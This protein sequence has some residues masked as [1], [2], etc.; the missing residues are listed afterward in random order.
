VKRST[1]Q[2]KT[3]CELIQLSRQQRA[4]AED[5]SY[6]HGSDRK[7]GVLQGSEVKHYRPKL[8]FDQE[9]S[10]TIKRGGASPIQ[11]LNYD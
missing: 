2:I 5:N 4:H 8:L 9:K 6:V 11:D 7:T 10:W 1:R 3:A